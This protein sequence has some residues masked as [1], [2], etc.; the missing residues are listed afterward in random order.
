MEGFSYFPKI[1]ATGF[2]NNQRFLN[3][4]MNEKIRCPYCGKNNI[5]KKGFRKLKKGSKPVYSCKDCCHK[6]SFGLGKK[7]FDIKVIL[8]AVCAYNQG[9]DYEEVCDIL[10]RKYKVNA[11][12]TSVFRWVMEYDLGYSGI[13]SKIAEKQKFPLV[14]GR[15]FKHF[16]LFYNFKCHKGKLEEFGKFPSLKNFI[17]S[18][19]RGVDKK[20]FSPNSERCS[21]IKREASADVKVFDNTKLNKVLGSALKM[22]KSSRQ[23]HSI[24]EDLML[25]CDRDTVAVE[26]P[27]WYWDKSKNIN[28][29][30]HID[31]LQVKFGKVWVLDYKPNAEQEDVDKV[32]S[33]LFSYAL[34][35]SFRTGI[36]LEDVSCGWFDE[37]KVYVF[38]AGEVKSQR[39][40][41]RK[42]FI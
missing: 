24:V 14:I 28:V 2:I 27:V 21:Q 18:L 5:M 36:R 41:D 34:G 37:N 11:C 16:G 35:L 12:L 9:Y 3:N 23:R 29:C 32:V 7:R 25:H 13:R 40:M 17:F 19:S 31:V 42:V 4:V 33:Q 1:L 39:M 6:F 30:G 10:C 20:Y 22:V 15:V 8:N 38:D 26:V